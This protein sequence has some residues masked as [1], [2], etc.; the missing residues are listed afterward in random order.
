MGRSLSGSTVIP[1]RFHEVAAVAA[2]VLVATY[3]LRQ[4]GAYRLKRFRQRLRP[5]IDA[6]L[7]VVFTAGLFDA[8]MSAI[9][10]GPADVKW[11]LSWAAFS[12]VLLAIARHLEYG[13]ITRGLRR[14]TLRRKIVLIGATPQAERLVRQVDANDTD[15]PSLVLGIY[16]D[17]SLARRPASMGGVKVLGDV[18]ALC[19]Y[20][21]T[22]PV[23]VVIIAL[24]WQRAMEM[25]RLIQRVQWM[26]AD[27]LIPMDD[28]TINA[29]TTQVS[30]IAGAAALQVTHQPLHGTRSLVKWLE[31]YVFAAIGV[32]LLTPLLTICALAI[33]LDSRGPVL[34]RQT[35]VGF[36]NSRFSLLRFR[37]TTV[38]TDLETANPDSIHYTRVG[39][40]LRRLGLHEVPQLFNVLRGDMSV[41]GP[42]PHHPDA[43]VGL[44]S[45]AELVPSY[46]ARLRTKPGITGWAQVNGI[47]GTVTTLAAARRCI[48]L[49]SY[50]VENWSF[51][52]DCRIILR[53]ITGAFAGPQAS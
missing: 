8:A 21:E 33:R 27:V 51:G 39:L 32:V 1:T 50:Y 31:D 41:V 4:L 20:A 35:R 25:F 5:I 11:L 42:H 7:A 18:D 47:A 13:W 46:G 29:R 28:G 10:H 34:S 45:F 43:Q 2:L 3:V 16:D 24:P 30:S 37:T 23:D 6:V 12:I 52:L 44:R 9:P 19:A 49:D 22:N 17:R 40:M 14:G 15:E 26:S 53:T 36:N 48:E 38:D